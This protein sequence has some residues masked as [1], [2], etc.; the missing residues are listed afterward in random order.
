ILDGTS[1]ASIKRIAKLADADNVRYDAAAGKVVIGYGKGALQLLDPGSGE[2]TAEIRLPAHPE[3]FQL[4][5][6]GT[7]IFVN[8]PDARQVAVVDRS[9]R[10][11]TAA[12]EVPGAR[13]NFPMP[14]DE[15]G[16]RFF[17]G[18]RSPA[19]MLVY[20]TDGGKLVAKVPIGDDTDDLFFDAQRK[21]VY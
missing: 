16:R 20:D 5:K 10:T 17:I 8:V 1:F 15:A 9:K 4:E 19:L 3:S 7:R 21:R 13:S 12:W 2:A 14:L 6:N 11:V 18:A